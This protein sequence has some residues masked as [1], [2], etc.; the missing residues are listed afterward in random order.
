MS[1]KP[2]SKSVKTTGNKLTNVIA[3]NGQINVPKARGQTSNQAKYSENV[4]ME[5]N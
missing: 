5:N 2:N 1:N 4:V 3:N